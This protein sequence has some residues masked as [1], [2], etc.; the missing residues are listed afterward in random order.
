MKYLKLVRKT[1]V[2]KD[3]LAHLT[4]NRPDV[5]NAF[6]PE[7]IEELTTVVQDLSDDKNLRCLIISGE[8]KSFCA[9]ADINWMKSMAGYDYLKNLSDAESLN[10]M[11][12]AIYNIPVPVIAVV[13]GHVMG[14]GLGI[15][16]ASDIIL[17]DKKTEFCFSEVKLGIAPAVI[18]PY[19]L[20]KIGFSQ[21]SRYLMSAEIFSSEQALQMGLI[22]ELGDEVEIKNK[23]Q[24]LINQIYMNA[25]L[26]SREAK[27]MIRSLS[28][29]DLD[30]NVFDQ[31]TSLIAKLR[32]DSEGQEGLKSFLNK[33]TPPWRNS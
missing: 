9:G 32:V 1:Q 10:K 8:G 25:P 29:I 3:D 7:M 12:L 31:T 11:F 13:H 23:L 21:A 16:S 2:K 27:K 17:S 15:V 20:Q 30:K 18:S 14:G 26:A 33:T 28:P 4:L 22:H 24:A 6:N 5:R 19:V